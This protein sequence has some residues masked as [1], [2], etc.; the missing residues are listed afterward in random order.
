MKYWNMERVPSAI[1]I[2]PA[3]LLFIFLY[4]GFMAAGGLG[5]KFIMIYLAPAMPLCVAIAMGVSGYR[6]E[7]DDPFWKVFVFL[8]VLLFL[9]LAWPIWIVGLN[10]NWR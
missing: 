8:N 6:K 10:W 7:R 3:E 5:V 2:F 9:M 1:K 4:I